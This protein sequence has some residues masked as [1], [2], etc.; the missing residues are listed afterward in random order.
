MFAPIF[1]LCPVLLGYWA[2]R[3][4][5]LLSGPAGRIETTLESDLWGGR[6]ILLGIRALVIPR[7]D[8]AN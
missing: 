6:H 8:S 2:A 4:A 1:M 3:T 7:T 5:L